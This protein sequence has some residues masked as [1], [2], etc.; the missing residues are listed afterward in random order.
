MPEITNFGCCGAL[1]VQLEYQAVFAFWLLS[2]TGTPEQTA[3]VEKVM[4]E[5]EVARRM[6]TILREIP[7]EKVG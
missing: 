6:T 1:Q 4:S 2:F 3:I 5:A 7:A